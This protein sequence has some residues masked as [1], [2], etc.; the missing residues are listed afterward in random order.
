MKLGGEG[1]A[2]STGQKLPVTWREVLMLLQSGGGV[3]PRVR[4]GVGYQPDWSWQ[5]YTTGERTNNAS[6][7]LVAVLAAEIDSEQSGTFQEAEAGKTLVIGE[8]GVSS[9][10]D[11]SVFGG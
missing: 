7:R 10:A 5:I 1:K 4:T 9:H 8:S 3:N 6:E 11:S 2:G